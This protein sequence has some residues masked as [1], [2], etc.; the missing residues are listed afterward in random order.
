MEKIV[1]KGENFPLTNIDEH[2]FERLCVQLCQEL[3]GPGTSA[4]SAGPD[5]GVDARFDG[6]AKEF[7]SISAPWEGTIIIQ[8]KHT[9][10]ANASC[11]D[12]N[13]ISILNNEKTKIKKLYDEGKIDYYLLF[14]NRSLSATH[15]IRIQEIFKDIGLKGIKIYG[16]ESINTLLGRFPRIVDDLKLNVLQ[17]PFRLNAEDLKVLINSVTNVFNSTSNSNDRMTDFSFPGINR[18]NK[19]NNLSLQFF[20]DNIQQKAYKYFKDIDSFLK[21]EGNLEERRKYENITFE[22][23]GKMH[24]LKKQYD[25]F[26]GILVYLFDF[27]L[28]RKPELEPQRYLIWVFLY[29]M[30]CNCDIGMK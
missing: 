6:K 7:P 19:K 17:Y 10:K 4:F 9:I 26:E 27:I 25:K 15:D 18:K 11:S 24:L 13:F 16:I 14:T 12:P 20:K 8:A 22:I 28:Q 5:G 30:Y 1:A 3:L 21:S 29:Y 23:Q 2:T